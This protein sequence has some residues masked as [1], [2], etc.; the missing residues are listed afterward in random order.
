MLA[1]E[2]FDNKEVVLELLRAGAIVDEKNE[3]IE[4][5]TYY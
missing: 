3:V 5:L 2:F 4:L 1:A